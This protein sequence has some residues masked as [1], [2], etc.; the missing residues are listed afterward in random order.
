MARKALTK[1]SESWKKLANVSRRTSSTGCSTH[2]SQPS[3][4]D[5]CAEPANTVGNSDVS[6]RLK[7]SIERLEAMVRTPQTAPS[8]TPVQQHPAKCS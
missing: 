8:P 2:S 4:D 1:S 6:H 5:S 7:G 3:A